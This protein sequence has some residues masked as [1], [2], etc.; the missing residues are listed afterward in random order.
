MLEI[1]RGFSSRPSRRALFIRQY[2]TPSPLLQGNLQLQAAEI[3]LI[4]MTVC[5]MRCSSCNAI[6]LLDSK[7]LPVTFPNFI[8]WEESLYD[9]F[10]SLDASAAEGCELCRLWRSYL[11]YGA[12][13]SGVP[14][15]VSATRNPIIIK[16]SNTGGWISCGK[17]EVSFQERSIHNDSSQGTRFETTTMPHS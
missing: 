11:V 5:K 13:A 16:K 1:R 12:A 15:E 7:S 9:S 3:H 17:T 2:C 14:I 8:K 4:C 10:E 6:A